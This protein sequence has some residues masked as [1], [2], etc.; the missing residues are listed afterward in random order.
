MGSAP[1][2][3]GRDHRQRLGL[4][5]YNQEVL[6]LQPWSARLILPRDSLKDLFRLRD[7][8]ILSVEVGQRHVMDFLA[9]A[10]PATVVLASE[11]ET[12]I[13]D[14]IGLKSKIARH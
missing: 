7:R 12:R 13:L 14:Q 5:C 11:R 1:Y 9:R 4:T 2:G 8:T 3:Q 6:A 10:K